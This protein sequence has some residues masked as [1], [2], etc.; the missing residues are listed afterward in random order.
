MVVVRF[1]SVTSPS[2]FLIPSYSSSASSLLLRP[3]YGSVHMHS[4]DRSYRLW[5]STHAVQLTVPI[6]DDGQR[7]PFPSFCIATTLLRTPPLPIVLPLGPSGLYCAVVCFSEFRASREAILGTQR[8]LHDAKATLGTQ[9]CFLKHLLIDFFRIFGEAILGTQ[10]CLLKHL[11]SNSFFSHLR[12]GD[13]R[14]T[15]ILFKAFAYQTAFAP[16]ARRF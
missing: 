13:F 2:F 5:L 11:F 16:P 12:Q 15:T 14:Y 8:Y 10:R 7:C 9:Q 1:S 4:A 6:G 3:S